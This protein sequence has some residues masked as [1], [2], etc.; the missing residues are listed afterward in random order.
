[1]ALASQD[2]QNVVELAEE[3]T[4]STDMCIPP[5]PPIILKS[6]LL[7]NILLYGVI[8][9]IS[10]GVDVLLF[11]LLVYTLGYPVLFSNA[12]TVTIGITI[13][14]TLNRK[15]NFKVTDRVIRRYAM[16]FSAGMCGLALSELILFIGSQA[17]AE[18]FAVKVISVFVVAV[19]QFVL[20]RAISFKATEATEAVQ[21]ASSDD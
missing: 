9:V 8:G 4:S 19:I 13:S 5:P 1:M 21:K 15:Y 2:M 10:A 20:N 16:F 7:R 3:D 14:F 12:F 18:P 11:R 17:G 6:E